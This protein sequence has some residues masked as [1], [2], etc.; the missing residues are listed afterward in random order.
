[1]ITAMEKMFKT[2]KE[3]ETD[4]ITTFFE[5]YEIVCGLNKQQL[6]EAEILFK[7]FCK[8][9]KIQNIEELKEN[10]VSL[11]K[12]RETFQQLTPRKRKMLISHVNGKSYEEICKEV[13][14]SSRST[15]FTHV[16]NMYKMFEDAVQYESN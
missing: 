1:M 13:N 6:E 8:I 5:M 10:S 4:S 15:V 9:Y 7:I 3:L 16:Q 11:E 14:L 2:F 12:M